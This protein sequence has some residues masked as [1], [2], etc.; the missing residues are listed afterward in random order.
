[1]DELTR[2]PT[3]GTGRTTVDDQLPVLNSDSE[4]F[5][6]VC[7]TKTEKEEKQTEEYGIWQGYF[8]R[9]CRKS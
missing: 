3:A 7:D 1:M 2:L 9:F 5:K 6:V 8:S 4:I